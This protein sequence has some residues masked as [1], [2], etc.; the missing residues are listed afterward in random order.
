MIT[1]ALKANAKVI[2]LTPTPDTRANMLD[3]ND[4]LT[5][6]ANLIRDLAK[7]NQVDLADPYAAFTQLLQ[8][9]ESIDPYMSQSNH[10][11]RKGHE[12][13]AKKL[14]ELFFRN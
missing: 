2:L 5:Q 13:V 14:T 6:R 3:L 10:P 7:T 1:T 9:K 8:N 4:P 12:V 11:N